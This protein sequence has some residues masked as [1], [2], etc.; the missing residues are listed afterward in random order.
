MR[1]VGIP[2]Y[3]FFDTDVNLHFYCCHHE[4]PDSMQ[5]LL[6]SS[7]HTTRNT[8]FICVAY[9]RFT[10]LHAYGSDQNR[11]SVFL[12]AIHDAFSDFFTG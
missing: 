10:V 4:F 3:E 1:Y 7:R 12:S 6:Q 11:F 2:Y 5:K 9:I 8:C